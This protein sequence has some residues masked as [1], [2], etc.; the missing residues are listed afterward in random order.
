MGDKELLDYAFAELRSTPKKKATEQTV[1]ADMKKVCKKVSPDA[2]GAF[3]AGVW[4]TI[5]YLK[6][7]GLL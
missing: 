1:M 2:T 5:Q 4:Y 7:V 3:T 6:E